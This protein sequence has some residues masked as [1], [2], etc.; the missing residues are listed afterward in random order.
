MDWTDEEVRS[1]LPDH[2]CQLPS[3]MQSLVEKYDSQELERS[4][5][6]FRPCDATER[7]CSYDTEEFFMFQCYTM[8][9]FWVRPQFTAFKRLVLQLM[10]V[11]PSQLTTNAW[12]VLKAF[13]HIYRGY[14][15]FK[16]AP[17]SFFYFFNHSTRSKNNGGYIYFNQRLGGR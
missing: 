9:K 16:P 15:N 2:N 8:A 7:V 11:A 10:R 12:L 3:S 5:M 1:T 17:Y 6:I 4:N 14:R 13:E